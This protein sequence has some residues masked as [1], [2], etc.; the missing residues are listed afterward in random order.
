MIIGRIGLSVDGSGLI[1]L[2]TILNG[3]ELLVGS[4]GQ[5]PRL[6]PRNIG[7]TVDLRV[8]TI[9]AAEQ[10]HGIEGSEQAIRGH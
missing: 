4:V 6:D 9:A 8:W 10:R 1:A 2:R 5:Q 3:S 7:L